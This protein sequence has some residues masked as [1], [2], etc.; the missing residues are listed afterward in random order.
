MTATGQVGSLANGPILA[1][2][3]LGI[4][5]KSG[6][7]K[8]AISGLVVGLVTNACLWM[9]VPQ[10]SWLWWNVVGFMVAFNVGVIVSNMTGRTDKDL[11]GLVWHPHVAN[12]FDYAVDWPKR[13]VIMI[14]Y[15]VLMIGF[16]AT[17]GLWAYS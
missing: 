16:C 2:F 13:Y 1:M 6:N 14:G 15:S 5:T 12:A 4:L 9:F 17:L 8:G 7:E 11:S 3:L 10:I